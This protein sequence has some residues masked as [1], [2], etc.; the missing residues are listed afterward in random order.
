MA[1]A[2]WAR[3]RMKPRSSSA[4][5]SRWMPD[6]ERRSSASFIS[7]KEGGTP[8]R[9][10][11]AWMNC[12]RSCCLRVSMSGI[13]ASAVAAVL[14]TFLICVKNLCAI[15][16]P[17][18]Y[19]Q[20]NATVSPAARAGSCG[21]RDQQRVGLGEHAEQRAVLQRRAACRSSRRRRRPRR[22]RACSGRAGRSASTG[23]ASRAAWGAG[24]SP[25]RPSI[26]SIAGRRNRCAVTKRRHRVAGQADERH[27]AEAAGQ[28]RLARAHGDA[29]GSR[30]RGRGSRRWRAPGRSRR[31]RRRRS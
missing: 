30:R 8:S 17:V 28:Q 31:P 24:G 21:G 5:I 11:R 19:S 10:S 3:R 6:F 18:G 12:R 13:L 27:A 2:R 20:M 1:R 7:S 22:G 9:C 25:G 15:Q 23:A 4:V 16:P 26:R 29:G 14:V